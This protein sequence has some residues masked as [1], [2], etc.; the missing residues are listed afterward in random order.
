MSVTTAE[1]IW[2]RFQEVG[3][4]PDLTTAESRLLIDLYRKLA[5]EGR[6][7][8][9]TQLADLAEVAGVEPEVS[10][11]LIRRMGERD[12]A[13]DIRGIMGLSLNRHPHRFRVHGNEL[14]TWC[15]LD[16]L[17]IAPI[18]TDLVEIEFA[19]KGMVAAS[20]NGYAVLGEAS[21]AAV[22][23]AVKKTLA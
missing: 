21:D 9:A 4:V 17:V 10:E 8:P 6:P 5:S 20:Y 15:A 14:A 22:I 23:E 11:E 13:G 12:D 19:G 2:E 1:T 3:F 7:V 16:P 18:M